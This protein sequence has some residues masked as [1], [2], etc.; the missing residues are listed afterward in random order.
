MKISVPGWKP[1]DYRRITSFTRVVW[2]LSGLTACVSIIGY[3]GPIVSYLK[4]E[5]I[6]QIAKNHMI[7]CGYLPAQVAV[8]CK[9]I[10][11]KVNPISALAF[12]CIGLVQGHPITDIVLL[13]IC[14]ASMGSF[15]MMALEK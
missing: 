11:V 5:N 2:E 6:A 7:S 1:A 4:N 14:F 9:T 15:C 3:T 13:S 10:S 8:D 12:C